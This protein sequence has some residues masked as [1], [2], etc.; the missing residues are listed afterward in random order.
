ML[1]K[2]NEA[3][4]IRS[5]DRYRVINWH[6][7]NHGLRRRGEIAICFAVATIAE[8]L[9]SMTGALSRPQEYSEI[10]IKTASF[11]S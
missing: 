4:I 7:Y 5:K 3:V 9:P 11:I 10:A 2:Y 8:W 6:E 1:Y